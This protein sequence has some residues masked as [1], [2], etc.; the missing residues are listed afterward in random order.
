MALGPITRR[1][2]GPR[3][4][5]LVGEYYR[6]I[7]VD[8]A[9]VAKELAGVIPRGAHLLDVGGGDGLPLNHLLSLRP[10]ISITTLDPAP[11]VG[12]WINPCYEAQVS[13]LTCTSLAEFVASSRA[14]PD[15]LLIA[16]VMHHIPESGRHDFLDSVRVLLDRVPGLRII[17]K[18]VE[19]GYW[20]AR[21]GFWCDRYITGDWNV[22]LISRDDV[23]RLFEE[24][25]GPLHREDTGLFKQDG[26]NYAIVYC[27]QSSE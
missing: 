9:L 23:T 6:A 26:P 3:L 12:Q 27:R 15:I 22:S 24:V 18:D 5:R 16:D 8:L 7:F 2:L 11:I 13:R 17:V 20:R 25:V 14:H 1:F 21:L 19:P 4:A 10:D